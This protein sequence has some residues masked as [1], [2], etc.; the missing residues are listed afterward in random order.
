MPS[1][2]LTDG[3]GDNVPGVVTYD[4]VT[5]KATFTPLAPLAPH[6]SYNLLVTTAVKDVAGN[7]MQME[8]TLLFDTGAPVDVIP[9]YISGVFPGPDSHN[10]PVSS[11]MVFTFSEPMDVS[12]L[13]A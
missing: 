12:T 1:F 7:A 4:A 8:Y 9:P 6:L 5:N 13:T 2:I 11:G 10:V 3:N